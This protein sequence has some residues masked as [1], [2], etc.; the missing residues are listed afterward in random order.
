[1]S[2]R[3]IQVGV[4]ACILGEKVR[5][6][7]GH[8]QSAFV[9]NTLS[10][11]FDFVPVC[12]E[13]GV[14][15]TVPRPT[16]RLQN[17][18]G[19]TRLIETKNPDND[20]TDAMI[21]Y[22]VKK[23]KSLTDTRLCGY[24]VCAKSPTCGMERV[25]V[26]SEHQAEKSGVGLFTA[27]LMARMPWLPIEEDGRLHDPHLKENFI[28]R[29][30]ALYDFYNSVADNPTRGNIVAFHSRYKLTLMA[31]SPTAYKALGKLVANIAE[32]EVAA[33]F[34][35]YRTQFMQALSHRA[36]RKNN[37]NVL[38]HIQGYFK[39]DL[40]KEQKAELAKLIDDYRLGT[41]PLLAPITLIKHYLSQHP[42]EYLQQQVFLS[43]HPQ[44]LSLRYGL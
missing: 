8:K 41:L 27:E 33:F 14:G 22:S 34:E 4:S 20:H 42:D 2:V 6:D 10:K 44:E 5:F 39:R 28:S 7:G 30:Y 23:V 15:M 36:S 26:Y 11:V 9:Q 37:T 18:D 16:I 32:Y 31:H 21:E 1:M 25:K 29:V 38:M 17:V 43:P 12:P 24:I 40:S 13:V 35:L 19:A 3:P